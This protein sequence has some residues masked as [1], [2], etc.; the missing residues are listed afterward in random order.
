MAHNE[1]GTWEYKEVVI[2]DFKIQRIMD[3]ETGKT[4]AVLGELFIPYKQYT[5]RYVLYH[6]MQIFSKFTSQEAYCPG[7]DK[8]N[9]LDV[10]KVWLKWM[11]DHITTLR[12]I[13]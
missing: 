12:D 6:L 2:S 3:Q 1:D 4:H 11:R 13:G 8:V 5:I 9:T 10:L 7:E